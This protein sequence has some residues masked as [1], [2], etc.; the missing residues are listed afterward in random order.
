M[1]LLN[2]IKVIDKKM[3]ALSVENNLC[4]KCISPKSTCQNCIDVCPMNSIS[5]S[6]KELVIDDSCVECGL[7]S[8][9]C[10]TGA[11]SMNRPSLPSFINDLVRTCEQNEKVY[12]HCERVSLSKSTATAVSVS[13]LGLLPKEAWV[14]LLNKCA[15][16]SVHHLDSACQSCKITTGESVWRG[17]LKAGEM[18]S[19]K[20]MTI[21]SRINEENKPVSYDLGRRAFLASIFSEVKSTNKLAIKEWAG[22]AAIPSYQEKVAVDSLSKV[23][24]EWNAVSNGMV[25]K[26]TRESVYPYMKK[27]SLFLTELQGSEGLQSQSDIRLPKI[28]SDCSFCNACTI[29]CPT[30]AIQMKQVDGKQVIT[31]QPQKCVDCSLCEEICYPNS[32]ELQNHPNRTLLQE[33]YVIAENE[34]KV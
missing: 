6:K 5:F 20:R 23:K 13:C 34:K 25:E 3:T 19:G 4:T 29:L 11:L 15:N 26:V 14:K 8:T 16:L 30:E 18:I 21:T 24:K 1:N 27:R 32:I 28:S 17:E 12:L 33:E 22:E 2:W 31:L 7:C 9:V 10:P